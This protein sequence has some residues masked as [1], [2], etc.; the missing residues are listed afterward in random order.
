MLMQL[1]AKDRAMQI[2]K[3][4]DEAISAFSIRQILFYQDFPPHLEYI[5]FDTFY[6]TGIL[7]LEATYFKKITI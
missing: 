3:Y 5:V 1:T 4:R 7:T 2:K 6:A